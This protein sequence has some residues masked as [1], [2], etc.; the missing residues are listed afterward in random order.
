M[1]VS[2]VYGWC[3]GPH[4]ARDLKRELEANGHELIKNAREADVIIAHS[5]GCY[6]IPKESKVS[7]ILL[8]GLPYGPRKHLPLLTLHKVITNGVRSVGDGQFMYWLRKGFWNSVYFFIRPS[9]HVNLKRLNNLNYL[10]ESHKQKKVLLIKNDEDKLTSIDQL[11]E[12][13]KQK[14]WKVII[15]PG[16]HDDLWMNPNRYI[17]LI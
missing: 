13:I 6:L 16:R 14:D 2:I 10:P 11:Q 1:K 8:T 17:A 15:V 3:E 12:V 9:A 4:L 5:L 7:N